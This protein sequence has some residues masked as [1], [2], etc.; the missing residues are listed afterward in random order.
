MADAHGSGPCV[1]K[2]VR[3]Q[4]PPRPRAGSCWS[5]AFGHLPHEPRSFPGGDPPDPHVRRLPSVTTVSRALLAFSLLFGC[6]PRTT[7]TAIR[8]GFPP[9]SGISGALWNL[10]R[11]NGRWVTWPR[12]SVRGQVS[13]WRP[14][15]P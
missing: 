15:Q 2:D 1:R 6:G 14:I 10:S 4:I 12:S 9:G 13:L 7:G 5:V 3:V 8:P 11:L